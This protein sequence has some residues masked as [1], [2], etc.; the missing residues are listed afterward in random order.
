MTDRP[1][2]EFLDLD[3]VLELRHLSLAHYGGADGV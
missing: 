2:P 1:E 3:D